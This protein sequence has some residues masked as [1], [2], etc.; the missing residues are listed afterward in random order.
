MCKAQG[1]TWTLNMGLTGDGRWRWTYVRTSAGGLFRI[2]DSTGSS[3][4]TNK[5]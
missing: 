5:P 3:L 4:A 2:Q 1:P